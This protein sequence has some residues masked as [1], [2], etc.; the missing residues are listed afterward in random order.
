[1]TLV[2]SVTSPEA[3]H[4]PGGPSPVDGVPAVDLGHLSQ[5]WQR[6]WPRFAPRRSKGCSLPTSRFP[7]PL[8]SRPA[9]ILTPAYDPFAVTGDPNQSNFRVNNLTPDRVTLDRL[10]RRRSMVKTLDAFAHEVSTTP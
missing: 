1:M 8:C 3:D 2:R 4:R 7:T 10:R 9:V 6:R 5:F